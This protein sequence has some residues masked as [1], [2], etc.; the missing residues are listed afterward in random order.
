MNNHMKTQ[1]QRI[2]WLT[3]LR[4]LSCIAIIALYVI[5][6]RLDH[7]ELLSKNCFILSAMLI[8]TRYF[9]AC[10]VVFNFFL[11]YIPKSSMG[12]KEAALWYNVDTEGHMSTF[13]SRR[14]EIYL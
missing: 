9:W 14:E 6:N 5:T 1:M 13:N 12:D 7:T 11:N 8:L 3:N 10:W 4:A 2:T